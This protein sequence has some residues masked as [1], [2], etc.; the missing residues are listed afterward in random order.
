MTRS[1]KRRTAPA[2]VKKRR[3]A[4]R[5]GAATGSGRTGI[6]MYRRL[7]AILRRRISRGE[8]QTG[9]RLPALDAL[10][11]EFGVGR[12]TVRHALDLLADEGLIARHRDR[13]GSSIIRQPLDGRW[14]TLALNLAELETHSTAVTVTS[15]G[16]TPWDRPLPVAPDEGKPGDAYHRVIHLHHHKDFPYPVAMTDILV[17]R[18]LYRALEK[19]GHSDRPILERLAVRHA[20]L[21]HIQQTFTIGEADIELAEKLS[22]HESAPVA[23]L[24]RIVRN[25]SGTIVY[26]GH[27]FFRGDL[28]RLDFSVD[29]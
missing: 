23:E 15:I 8:W 22:L 24:R 7:A 21:G 25:S 4:P 12:I 10:V 14:F 5:Q 2:V 27:L 20:D 1:T 9:D 26:F 28:V 18:T 3:T 16:S 6:A 13:R 11:K 17:E 19:E 29:L